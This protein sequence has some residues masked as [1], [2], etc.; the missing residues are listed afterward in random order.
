METL[1]F[2]PGL[3]GSKKKEGRMM[4][5]T[6]DLNQS[7]GKTVQAHSHRSNISSHLD[8]CHSMPMVRLFQDIESLVNLDRE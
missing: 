5:S 4:P 8:T 3:K 7:L 1:N 2:S 6:Q